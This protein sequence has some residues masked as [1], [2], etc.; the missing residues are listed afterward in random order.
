MKA[1]LIYSKSESQSVNARKSGQANGVNLEDNRPEASAAFQ[2]KSIADQA[3]AENPVQLMEGSGGGGGSSSERGLPSQL[4]SGVESLSGQ[5]M[6][7]VK[8]HYNSDKPAQL[9][10]H[11]YAQGPDIHLTSGQEKHLPHEAWHV[12]QQKQG[13]VQPVK[14]MKSKVP[15][16]DDPALEKEADVMGAKAASL[17]L[18]EAPT[19]EEAN[20]QGHRAAQ[21]KD[22]PETD[23]GEVYGFAELEMSAMSEAEEAAGKGSEV[24]DEEDLMEFDSIE[25]IDSLVEEEQPERIEA[26]KKAELVS[27]KDLKTMGSSESGQSRKIELEGE[28]SVGVRFKALFGKKSTYTLFLEK[29]GEFNSSSD[30]KQ[31]QKLLKDHLKPLARQWLERHKEDIATRNEKGAAQDPNEMLKLATIN[32]FLSQTTSN[33]WE[34]M[35]LYKAVHKN[36]GMYI[37][38]PSNG[39]PNFQKACLAYTDLQQKKSDYKKFYPPALNVLYKSEMADFAKEEKKLNS[40]GELK[41][42][43]FATSLGFVAGELK[44][45]TYDLVK[46]ESRFNGS[47]KFKLPGLLAKGDVQV[48]Q[49]SDGTYKNVLVS[50]EANYTVAD[51]AVFKLKGITYDHAEGALAVK[52]GSADVNIFGTNVKLSVE[53][54]RIKNGEID[55]R[56]IKGSSD[57]EINTPFGVKVGS[58][59]ISIKPNRSITVVGKLGLNWT[60]VQGKGDVSLAFD[61]KGALSEI[62]SKKLRNVMVDNG[63]LTGSLLDKFSFV[64]DGIDYDHNAHRIHATTARAKGE[65][66]K[67]T[68]TVRGSDVSYKDKEGFDFKKLSL[69]ASGKKHEVG[70]LSITPKLYSLFKKDNKYGIQ[71]EGNAGLDL[72]DY[73][74]ITVGG[75][76]EGS[77]GAHLEGSPKPFYDIKSGKAKIEAENPLNKLAS[78]LGGSGSRFELSAGIPV[79][80]GISAIFGMYL[81]YG[82]DL[83]KKLVAMVE[84]KDDVLTVTADM[85]E[86]TAFVEAGVFGGVQAGNSLLLALAIMLVASGRAELKGS[87]G[88]TKKYPLGK[89]ANDGEFK[90]GEQGLHYNLTG[91]IKAGLSLEVVAT[92][93]YFFN[94]SWRWTFAEKDL[95]SFSFS[96]K[97]EPELIEGKEP[98]GSEEKLK[99]ESTLSEAEKPLFTV[100]QLLDYDYTKRFSDDEKK[101]AVEVISN[102]EEARQK[103]FE[104]DSNEPDGKKKFDNTALINLNLFDEFVTNRVGWDRFM[105][106]IPILQLDSNAKT[107]SGDQTK[108]LLSVLNDMGEDLNLATKFIGHYEDKIAEFRKK[109]D[110]QALGGAALELYL[111]MKQKRDVMKE[112][113]KFKQQHL[114][115]KR[116]TDAGLQS[117]FVNTSSWIGDSPYSSMAKKYMA[118]RKSVMDNKK[119]LPPTEDLKSKKAK[120]GL[121]LVQEHAKSVGS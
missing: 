9:N 52:T 95:G 115:S 67:E 68:Y 6:D 53:G 45:A 16:N 40:T 44:T 78:L 105:K 103:S 65:F 38:S 119:H 18:Q 117:E 84:V 80:P 47:L 70:V 62:S 88:Y 4:K 22:A 85:D 76:L 42:A 10:A 69:E 27:D 82:A 41:M 91:A 87:V 107:F 73:L 86:F 35:G 24:S 109:Y 58:P 93:L 1:K 2:L 5:S 60:N 19:L 112:M 14:Q 46:E 110:P 97:K 71:A 83:G 61:N 118:L 90:K 49:R 3:S 99:S 108:Y 104:K 29:A 51:V 113:N 75:S 56:A 13:R 11:A 102:A 63:T 25:D 81:E 116:K 8:V 101:K 120:A 72:P 114:H 57:A 32:K 92:A 79:F 77:V 36:L 66:F 17:Q 33:Y 100:E 37:Q 28:L 15:I 121:Q 21:L 59:F 89:K 39:L 50:G 96:N 43:E 31:K 54:G 74:G 98:I 20:P 7:D 106:M 48:V 34:V 23:E 64:F 30:V 12:A 94:S 55:Y 26:E 111:A